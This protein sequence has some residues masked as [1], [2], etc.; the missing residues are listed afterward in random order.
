MNMRAYILDD[1]QASIDTLSYL[2]KT[3]CPEIELVGSSGDFDKAVLE[4]RMAAI[5]IL[6]LDVNLGNNQTA[7]DLLDKLPRFNGNIIMITAYEE[8]ALKAFKYGAVHYLLKP[9]DVRELCDAVGRVA[10]KKAKRPLEDT[11]LSAD[12]AET[13]M[14]HNRKGIEILDV[15]DIVYLEG[16]GSYAKV[17]MINAA[18]IKVPK[19]LK[20]VFAKLSHHTEFIKVHRSYIVNNKYISNYLRKPKPMLELAGKYQIP[21]SKEY[22]QEVLKDLKYPFIP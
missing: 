6:F 12:A 20:F 16:S 22:K 8:Y 15:K 4:I 9:I 18:E 11:V 19:N 17:C 1:L 5:D 3:Y 21:V 13:I 2:L 7:F 10:E 14:F